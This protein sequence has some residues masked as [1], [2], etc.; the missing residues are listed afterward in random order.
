MGLFSMKVTK[1]FLEKNFLMVERETVLRY[2][3]KQLLQS[4]F[5]LGKKKR[6][7]KIFF[8]EVF[9]VFVTLFLYMHYGFS[10]R[11]VFI[12]F[13]SAILFCIALID[14]AKGIIPDAL[15][16]VLG[17]G[18]IV[19]GFFQDDR[20]LLFLL[21]GFAAG[22]SVLWSIF[23]LSRGGMGEG[24]IKFA[25]VMGLWLGWENSLLML[26]LAFFFGAAAGLFLLES[27]KVSMQDA[28]PFGPFLSGAGF[29][30]CI[31]GAEI[32]QFYRGCF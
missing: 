21:E 28:V 31:Y 16:G 18:A 15:L 25:A 22:G 27:H 14:G 5:F 2:S 24:D 26:F 6:Y 12:S 30:S 13:F 8:T 4:T 29:I 10:N 3:G 20:P 23:L 11:F 19:F 9:H 7:K 1:Y 32:L 17:S